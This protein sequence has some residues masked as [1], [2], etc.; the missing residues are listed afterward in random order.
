ML[1]VE[2]YKNKILETHNNSAL[3]IACIIAKERGVQLPC[4]K[5]CK[6]CAFGS[7]EWIFNEVFLKNEERKYLSAVIEPFKERV[8]S[9]SKNS[10]DKYCA[11]LSI[12]VKK[13]EGPSDSETIKIPIFEKEKMYIGLTYGK[14]Y[15]LRDLGL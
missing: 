12:V 14:K 15:T 6:D 8:V 10:N 4:S 5:D 11:W 3:E 2:K 7:I 9:I 13:H 1:N